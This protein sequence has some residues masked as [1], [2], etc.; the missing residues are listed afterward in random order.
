MHK[1][2]HL[3]LSISSS[4]SLN[5]A[6]LH[7][8]SFSL[9][10]QPPTL[11]WYSEF[12]MVE[13]RELRGKYDKHRTRYIMTALQTTEMKEG[14]RWWVP[15]LLFCNLLT[16]ESKLISLSDNMVCEYFQHVS[17]LAGR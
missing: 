3:S 11:N 14:I 16:T 6:D 12:N 17:S 8:L 7:Q 9:E 2:H 13:L 5:L 1:Y 10:H 4:D 15:D